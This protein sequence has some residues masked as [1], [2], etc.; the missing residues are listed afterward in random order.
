MGTGVTHDTFQRLLRERRQMAGTAGFEFAISASR[1]PGYTD[2]FY[3]PIIDRG[4]VSMD[5]LQ[6]GAQ[7][8]SEKL[9]LQVDSATA[10]SALSGLM[11][12]GQ[13]NFDLAGLASKMASTGDL[14]GIVSSWLGDGANSAI[15]ADSIVGLLGDSRVSDFAAQLGTDKDSAA[16]GLAD[17]LP[18]LMDKASSGGSLLDSAG[19][20]GGLMGAAKSFLS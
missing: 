11:G 19:G 5:I 15:S 1:N 6:L 14:G 20:L 13:G 3:S 9:G 18:Q 17:V 7:M 10:A 12:D 4:I 2:T 8:L 16:A